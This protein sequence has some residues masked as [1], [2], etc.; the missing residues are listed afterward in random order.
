MDLSI[1]T[2]YEKVG[3]IAAFTAIILIM[4]AGTAVQIYEHQDEVK[5]DLTK[6]AEWIERTSRRIVRWFSMREN[7]EWHLIED[8]ADFKKTMETEI[9]PFWKVIE[10]LLKGS[11]A[12]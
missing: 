8:W 10:F 4:I 1:F 12:Q 3:I 9:P 6:L 2:W 7:P 5:E 11:I